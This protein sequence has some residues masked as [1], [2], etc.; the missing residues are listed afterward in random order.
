MKYGAKADNDSVSQKNKAGSKGKSPFV[1]KTKK[2][3][4]SQT[5][6]MDLPKGKH[7]CS[8]GCMDV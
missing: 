2:S 8:K 3:K 5:H 4:G 6:A 1:V 7:S